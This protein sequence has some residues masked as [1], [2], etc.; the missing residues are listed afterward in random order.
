MTKCDF[1]GFFEWFFILIG[2]FIGLFCT[3]FGAV[4]FHFCL[5]L[6]GYRICFMLNRCFSDLYTQVWH[7]PDD[8]RN[9]ALT[10]CI[11]SSAASVATLIYFCVNPWHTHVI[12]FWWIF[13]IWC[14]LSCSSLIIWSSVLGYGNYDWFIEK[15]TQDLVD[16]ADNIEWLIEEEETEF[17]R[18]PN[19]HTISAGV[20]EA[21]TDNFFN[22]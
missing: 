21:S 13:I 18:T 5:I 9:I 7:Q 14:F 15:Q 20:Q 22:R 10:I 16:H 6:F 1:F 8:P 3:C 19:V 11:L 12:H 2:R 4:Y 17:E